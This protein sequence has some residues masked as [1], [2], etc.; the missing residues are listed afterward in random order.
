LVAKMPGVMQKSIGALQSRMGPLL[1]KIK[2]AVDGAL[3]EA[4]VKR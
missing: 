3:A 1:E 4:G 2:V